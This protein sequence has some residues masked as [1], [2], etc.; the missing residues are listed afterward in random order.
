MIAGNRSILTGMA[1]ILL[2]VQT[3]PRD[4]DDAVSAAAALGY[5][6]RPVGGQSSNLILIEAMTIDEDADT[7]DAATTALQEQV[8]RAVTTALTEHGI[9]HQ[10]IGIGADSSSI[11]K[12]TFTIKRTG[13]VD[14]ANDLEIRADGRKEFEQRLAA[15]HH[16]LGAEDW[17]P[18]D[19]TGYEVIV[20]GLAAADPD[21]QKPPFRPKR[22]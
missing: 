14:G 13:A 7:Q 11:T 1:T 2:T 9:Q 17:P 18:Q 4:V 19:L 16:L 6:A 20:E 21:V 8:R 3:S 5:E 22:P 15:L 12:S 10:L